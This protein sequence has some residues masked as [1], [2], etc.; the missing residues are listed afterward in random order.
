MNV[1]KK[2]HT[3]HNWK[4]KRSTLRNVRNSVDSFRGGETKKQDEAVSQETVKY[5]IYVASFMRKPDGSISKRITFKNG[6]LLHADNGI[7]SICMNNED[8]TNIKTKLTMEPLQKQQ[9]EN[10]QKQ[11]E[12]DETKKQTQKTQLAAP[13]PEQPGPGP[14][15]VKE[16]QAPAPAP[17]STSNAIKA[18]T[19]VEGTQAP[20]SVPV[21][22][23][24]KRTQVPAPAPVKETQASVTVEVPPALVKVPKPTSNTTPVTG[25]GPKPTSNTTQETQVLV[26]DTFLNFTHINDSCFIAVFL[27]LLLNNVD[28]CNK[29]LKYNF[30]NDTIG[31]IFIEIQ[32]II[33]FYI[34]KS[35]KPD[36]IKPYSEKPDSEELITNLWKKLEINNVNIKF[37]KQYDADELFGLVNNY[38]EEY[39]IPNSFQFT[40]TKSYVLNLTIQTDDNIKNMI[41]PSDL[42]IVNDF[43]NKPLIFLTDMSF[44][45]IK[46]RLKGFVKHI[47]SDK[48]GHYVYYKLLSTGEWILLNDIDKNNGESIDERNVPLNEGYMYYYKQV[49]EQQ[50]SR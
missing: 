22:V 42:V 33:Q 25:P 5:D 29:I 36:S 40:L 6:K 14:A 2:S 43:R 37:G 34:T 12:T 28:L 13:V 48:S 21:P 39:N 27:Q 45:D 20:A 4:S 32:K 38:L 46:Y 18:P 19:Q 9:L 41:L 11:A 23:E 15:P 31:D 35:I 30:K 50:N 8:L 49:S 3:K 24:V 26:E 10:E 17:A 1:T 7:T 44:N 16:T 47:G